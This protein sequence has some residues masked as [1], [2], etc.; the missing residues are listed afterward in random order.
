ML[1]LPGGKK[2]IADIFNANSAAEHQYDLPF[3][4]SGNVIGTSFKYSANTKKQ[5]PLGSKNGYQ[6]LWKETEAGVKDTLAQFTY[7]NDK[8]YYTISSLITDSA[9]IFFTRLGANDPNYN[10]RRE[11]AYIIRKKGMDQAF[12]N[13][14]EI[15]GNYDPVNEFSTNAYP[16]VKK[17]QL[18]QNDADFTVAEITIDTKKI[19]IAQCN[20]DL[21]KQA[22]HKLNVTGN[23]ISWTGTYTVLYDGKPLK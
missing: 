4:Y 10:L 16:A 2:L 12:I 18:L 21:D 20:K 11:P 22:Q 8:T 3:Q 19:L 6:F 17:I 9:T 7:L 23:T 14:I 13:V 5:E 1:Q 15:H